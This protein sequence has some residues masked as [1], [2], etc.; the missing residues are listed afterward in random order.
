MAT[1]REYFE[2]DF[3]HTVIMES[4]IQLPVKDGREVQIESRIHLDFSSKALFA[5]FLFENKQLSTSQFIDL[6]DQIDA[7]WSKGW[8]APPRIK[9]PAARLYPG[10]LKID[11]SPFAA[12][13]KFFGG[14]STRHDQ[15]M[16]TGRIY[17]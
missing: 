6:I 7:L 14:P 10:E 11:T 8:P 1:L 15:L 13:S 5:S 9:L 17:I 3:S 12:T 4:P 16:F 2:A